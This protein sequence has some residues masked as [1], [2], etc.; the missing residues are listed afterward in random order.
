MLPWKGRT[1]RSFIGGLFLVALLVRLLPGFTE[2]LLLDWLVDYDEG[3]YVGGSNL[4]AQGFLPYR[5]FVFVHPPGILVWFSPT[6]LL[7]PKLALG[8][9]RLL[10][11]VVGSVNVALVFAI[12]GG[13][14][15]L[16]GA[17]VLLLSPEVLAVDRGAF[18][19]PVL[20]LAGLWAV[21]FA[22]KLDGARSGPA[23][24][25][26][27]TL[28][29]VFAGAALFIKTWG[30][31]W[32]IV[33]WLVCDV[34]WRW[35]LLLISG[36]VAAL[37]AAPFL[38][39]A[40]EAFF[41][42][43]ILFHA[44]RP[45]DGDLNRLVRLEQMFTARSFM[46]TALALLA[47]TAVRLRERTIERAA[48]VGV[49]LF[50]AALLAA[51]TYWSQYNAALVP[52]VALLVGGGLSR[53]LPRI[54]VRL[55]R[56]VALG[57]T[58]VLALVALQG[59]RA[60]VRS[61]RNGA[62][63][64]VARARHLAEPGGK[65]CAFEVFELLLQNRL[66]PTTA[67]PILLDSYGQMLLDATKAGRRYES[68]SAAFASEEAQLRLR[69]Q[70]EGCDVVSASWRGEWQMNAGTKAQVADEFVDVGQQA[71]VRVNR[72]EASPSPGTEAR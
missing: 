64:Q 20:T 19:E 50:S 66:P 15:G 14:A 43:T 32:L 48:L 72:R 58:V 37:A 68:A 25:R 23:G 67:R 1:H 71:F 9:A 38:L 27:A 44:W 65:V 22:R 63:P 12:V 2:G 29:G 69:R 56:R 47:V 8:A 3:V 16:I 49:L 33:T 54:E 61:R 10:S 39:L 34:R 41:E 5:D 35:R 52:L 4:L 6:A 53:I 26:L 40:P 45:P 42:Q 21:F 7:G 62:A 36:A 46:A 57:A 31:V 30:A 55:G 18:L 70:L 13:P 24:L 59:P 51:P 28:A 11:C 60:L 17:L